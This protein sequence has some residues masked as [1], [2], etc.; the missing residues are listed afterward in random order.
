V[1]FSVLKQVKV[2]DFFIA[3]LFASYA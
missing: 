3:F 1:N 2:I